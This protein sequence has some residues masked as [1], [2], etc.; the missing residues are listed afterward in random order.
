VT[1]SA[2]TVR[3]LMRQSAAALG[4]IMDGGPYVSLVLTA[5]DAAG[6]PL[7]LLSDLAQHS[8]NI[9]DNH[10]VS[11][12]FDGTAGLDDRLTGARVTLIGTIARIDDD[13]AAR[14]A[15]VQAHP[16]AAMYK[17]FGDFHLYRVSVERAHLVA[18]FGR[19]EWVEAEQLAG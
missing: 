11:L 3:A 13:E 17:G 1:D 15:Y 18:G 12:L 5:L 16:S 7:L 14:A 9:A 10:R 19:I 6:A 8:R 2:D 4:T